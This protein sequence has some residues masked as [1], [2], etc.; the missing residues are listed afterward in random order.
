M[1]KLASYLCILFGLTGLAISNSRTAM[2]WI[3]SRREAAWDTWW[4]GHHPDVGDL[5][6]MAYLERLPAYRDTVIRRYRRGAPGTQSVDLYM[7]GDSY[8]K[9]IPDSVYSGIR[10]FHF[11]RR[12]YGVLD[13]TLDSSKKN[14]LI[15]QL[16][17]RFTRIFLASPAPMFDHVKKAPQVAPAAALLYDPGRHTSSYAVFG[18]PW[19]SLN[20]LFNPDI[21]QNIEYNLFNYPFFTPVRNF[22]AELNARLF[23]RG[24]GDVAISDD[25]KWLFLK[26][27][28]S[29]HDILSAVVPVAT[30]ERE[31]ILQTLNTIYDHY[32]A[33]GFT[34]VYLSIVPNPVTILQP[35]PNNNLLA[36]I[37]NEQRSGR[38]KMPVIDVY[39]TMRQ[40]TRADTFYQRGD[41]H[42]G[43]PGIQ[44]WISK[45]NSMLH[46]WDTGRDVRR[47]W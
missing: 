6:K 46:S 9:D 40:S 33:A 12:D 39:E 2:S 32:R 19:G 23:R 36:D 4:G 16:G 5:S 11:V 31:R 21:N 30:E 20:G 44:L 35:V 29:P 3:S 13:Y 34:E 47:R 45:V 42:W 10:A 28:V 43:D 38:L 27:T 37:Q 26:G 22:K 15:V 24:S 17:E 8:V 14:I 41:S 18:F 1:R 25:G 7:I